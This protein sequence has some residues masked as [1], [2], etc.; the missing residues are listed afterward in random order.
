MKSPIM[1]AGFA[2]Y[3]IIVVLGMFL[4][5]S[6]CAGVTP[7]PRNP[8]SSSEEV[9]PEKTEDGNPSFEKEIEIDGKYDYQLYKT[10][11]GVV[12][13]Q[14]DV[15][16]EQQPAP[17]SLSD[18]NE[19]VRKNQSIDPPVLPRKRRSME[20]KHR[21]VTRRDTH[22]NDSETAEVTGPLTLN[23]DNADLYEVIRTFAEILK[24][25]YLVDPGVSGKVTI[26]TSGELKGKDLFPVFYQILEVNGFTAVKEGSFYRIVKL[27]DAARLPILSQYGTNPDEIHPS[28]KTIIQVI[29]LEYIAA[30]EMTKLL[31][32]FMSAEGSI[33]SHENSNTLVLV[34]KALNIHKVVKLVEAFDVDTLET[35]G[36]RFYTLENNSAE[37]MAKL[38]NDILSAHGSSLNGDFK[39]VPVERMNVLLAI[40]RNTRIFEK[41][42]YF[43]ERLDVVRE[44][45]E[46]Q[47]YIYFVKNGQAVDLSDVLN[48]IFS[49][50]DQ[51]QKPELTDKSADGEKKN[52]YA[53]S[54]LFDKKN[55]ADKAKPSASLSRDFQASGALRG[56]VR[57]TSDEIR[58]ALIIEATPSDYQ[59]LHKILER[60]DVM[61]RQ[62]L[63]EVTIADITLDESTD[64]GVEWDFLKGRESETGLLNATINGDS[65]LN[66]TIGLTEEWTHALSALAQDNKVNILSSPSVLASDNKEANIN[67]STQVPV[68]SAT[69]N[70]ESGGDGVV[71]TN[72]QYRDTGIILSVT[73]HINDNGLVS[74]EISQEV[75]EQGDGVEVLGEQYPSF[76]ERRV[77]TTLTVKHAQ[78]IVIGGLITE[79]RNQGNSGVPVLSRLPIFGYLF[80]SHSQSFN[81]TELIIMITPHVIVSLDDVD[82]VT[83]EFKSK[84]GNALDSLSHKEYKK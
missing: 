44:S 78:T 63:I 18:R 36:H 24:L 57:I 42:D 8:L 14:A 73:P 66:Y 61:P 79:T 25:N 6:A 40:S 46:S 49:N 69:Y 71:Q 70:Y 19:S 54:N 53:P 64:M 27:K 77:D 39:L 17:P 1:H 51:G 50:S 45:A 68:A 15:S 26:H 58:N 65:G 30:N 2:G 34:D 5:L 9:G 60:L 48:S 76:L 55:K 11:I 67:V 38:L 10:P 75:S 37:E 72:V 47:I 35:V 43:I 13:H 3:R 7:S 16:S 29:P 21:V 84:L 22:L 4:M 59:V 56:D 74:M 41:L 80:G 81:K 28:L 82:A 33:L 31:T 12:K 83:R 23:F 52:P 20:E 32:P 62:V